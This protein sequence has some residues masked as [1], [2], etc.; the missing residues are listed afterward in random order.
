MQYSPAAGLGRIIQGITGPGKKYGV[1]WWIMVAGGLIVAGIVL[2]A[3]FAE[4]IAPF[5][6]YDQNT[7]LSSQRPVVPTSW[8]RITCKETCGH[9]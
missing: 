9:G 1:E 7:G 4:S 2:M 8:A 6:P 3:L 5:D